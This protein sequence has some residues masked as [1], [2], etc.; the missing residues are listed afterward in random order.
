M[1]LPAVQTSLEPLPVGWAPARR[2]P[3]ESQPDQTGSSR[4]T[5]TRRAPTPEPDRRSDSQGGSKQVAGSERPTPRSPSFVLRHPTRRREISAGP[6]RAS[7]SESEDI[8]DQILN[9]ARSLFGSGPKL[10]R[11]AALIP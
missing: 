11:M 4:F 10:R 5:S 2:T 7:E 6:S 9:Q 1:Q 8:V 3:F